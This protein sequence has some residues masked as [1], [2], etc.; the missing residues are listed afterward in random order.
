MTIKRQLTI[1]FILQL[2]IAG[3]I[4]LLITAATIAWM[5]QRFTDIRMS[6]DFASIG[7]SRLVESSEMSK[8]GIR[9][10]PNLLEQVKSNGGWLQSLDEKGQ[11]ETSYNTPRDIP[12]RYLPGEL[13]SYW[14]GEKP[15][16]YML[17]LWI[18]DKGGRRF[19]LLYGEPNTFRPLFDKV[20]SQGLLSTEGKIVLP[21]QVSAQLVRL[22][23]YVQLLDQDGSE[24]A[25]YNRPD[26]APTTYT[27]QEL[28]LRTVYADRYGASMFSSYDSE[29]G[30][31][32]MLSLPIKGERAKESTGLLPAE[33]R[34]AIIG[35]IAM[36]AGILLLFLLLSLWQAH[37]FGAPMI[38]MLTWL[39]AIGKGKYEEPVDHRGVIRSRKRSGKWRRRYRVF[40]DVMHS[41]EK[42]SGTLQR[43]QELR[44]QTDSL[45]EEWIAGISH[46]LKTPLSS[47]KGYAH[48]LAEKQYEWSTEEVRKFSTTM[49][50]K[51]AHMDMLI[52]DLEMTYRLKNGARPPEA[53]ELELNSWL[54]ET[55]QQAAANPDYGL[56]RI[57]FQA[58][59]EEVIVSLPASWLERVVNNL[60]AN[61]LLHNPPDTVLTVTILTNEDEGRLIIQFSDN[62]AGMDEQTLNKLFERYYRGTDTASQANGTGLGMAISKGLIEAMGGQITVDT[63]LGEGTVIRLIWL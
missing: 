11:V 37:R 31:T 61:S 15:F 20:T 56:D 24:L 29:T 21:E 49:L 10:D 33:E 40:A 45:R 8:E 53:E 18:Q 58:A 23:A 36:F 52:N 51:S 6:H 43:N 62:G 47:I 27:L 60:T 46:D 4:V 39:N 5:L 7:L 50:E 34:T 22:G 1:R 54:R 35:I 19:T 48:L 17:Y 12:T 32:W 41:I 2:A 14:S 13:V 55:L 42:L 44:Q 3:L 26:S 9:F 63:V 59:P 38:Y 57:M 30:R 28:A 25:S 16:P